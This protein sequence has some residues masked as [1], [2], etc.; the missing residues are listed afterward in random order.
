MERAATRAPCPV[1]SEVSGEVVGC[2][3][4]GANT[5][6]S[7]LARTHASQMNVSFGI[8]GKWWVLLAPCRKA[9]KMS[10]ASALGVR[11]RRLVPE[12]VVMK[13]HVNSH[14]HSIPVEDSSTQILYINGSRGLETWMV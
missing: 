4:D 14:N 5:S 13:P 12:D 8:G 9:A 11:L 10:G 7:R 1:A 6:I 2:V 3:G